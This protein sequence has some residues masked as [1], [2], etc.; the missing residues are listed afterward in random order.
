M[1]KVILSV[2]LLLAASVW[3][4]QPLPQHSYFVPNLGQWDGEFAFRFSQGSTTYFLTETGMSLDLREAVPRGGEYVDEKMDMAGHVP[5]KQKQVVRGH[6][7][8]LSY[9]NANPHPEII[10]EDLLSHYSNYFLSRDSCKWRG[11]VPHYQKVIA[12]EVWPGIDV[13]YQA[14]EQGIE[15]IYHI[16]PGSDPSQIA[17]DYEGLDNPLS[18]DANGCLLFKTSLGEVKE[19]SPYAYQIHSHLQSQVPVQYYLLGEHSYGFILGNYDPSQEVVIDPILYCSYWGGYYDSEADC[20]TEDHDRHKLVAGGTWFPNGFPITPG[21]YSDSAG[22]WG[23]YLSKFS[24]GGDSLLF[25]TLLGG[26]WQSSYSVVADAGGSVYMAGSVLNSAGGS[27]P[28][29]PDAIDTIAGGQNEGFLVRLSPDGSTLEFGSYLGGSE[30]D[31]IMQ[32]AVDSAGDVYV[33]GNTQSPDFPVTP[34]ALYP[35]LTEAADGFIS[36]FN[37]QTS[38]LSYSSFFPGLTE[39]TGLTLENDSRIWIYGGVWSGNLPVTPAAFQSE[40]HGA[41]DAF[42][43][44]LDLESNELLYCTYLGGDPNTPETTEDYATN[45]IPLNG[46]TIL[47]C[48]G[49][50]SPDFPVTPDAFDTARVPIGVYY[51]KAFASMLV[52]PGTL[53]HSTLLGPTHGGAYFYLDEHRSVVALASPY[54]RRFPLTPNADDTTYRQLSVSRLSPDLRHLEFSTYL[55]GNGRTYSY[56]TL[57]E[58]RRAIWVVGGTYSPYLPVT[59]NALMPEYTGAEFLCGF[60]LR[61]AMPFDSSDDVDPFIPHPLSFSLLCYP[62]P[63]NPSTRIS[64]TLPKAGYVDLNVYDVTGRLVRRLAGG[65]IGPPLQAGE[66]EVVFDASDLPSGIY[67]A[68]LQA[69]EVSQTRKMVLLK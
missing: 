40:I 6:V 29:T 7:L 38:Q 52:L 41:Q 56:G 23:G 60:I 42:F 28:L 67:F 22:D 57:L 62:N 25:S 13:E 33:C 47:F 37:P 43:A 50:K 15:S 19:Q 21:A 45:V 14:S 61:Y 8:R 46:D 27:L 20:I 31:V 35:E 66:H 69:G 10:G 44:H 9:I 59:P 64:F 34:N 5:T 39:V 3:A 1:K 51:Y 16:Q 12:K 65:H 4:G 48:G 2:A 30:Y 53:L 17:I 63:F 54:D 18:V 68:R 11:H 24:A 58:N 26:A 49:T 36:V 32:L 55:C